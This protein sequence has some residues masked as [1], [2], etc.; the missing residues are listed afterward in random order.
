MDVLN[1]DS[2]EHCQTLPVDHHNM[3][4]SGRVVTTGGSYN[5]KAFNA[6]CTGTVSSVTDIDE[7]QAAALQADHDFYSFNTDDA[8]CITASS[9]D[10]REHCSNSTIYQ[11]WLGAYNS[12][13]A[14][15]DSIESDPLSQAATASGCLSGISDGTGDVTKASC[16][17][18]EG[19]KSFA[20]ANVVTKTGFCRTYRLSPDNICISLDG[21]QLLPPTNPESASQ[22]CTKTFRSQ[23]TIRV[24]LMPTGAMA[25]AF[26]N[27]NGHMGTA[28]A[29]C[30]VRKETI[31]KGGSCD[32]EKTVTC[33]RVCKL[34]DFDTAWGP[35]RVL[36][37]TQCDPTICEGEYAKAACADA[38][39][40]E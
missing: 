25:T 33:F 34:A 22:L 37:E 17:S 16:T 39:M 11:H 6:K 29:E 5:P 19:S 32:V 40:M 21:G 1:S 23:V 38:A 2:M 20:L 14:K 35:P 15:V 8:E 24:G 13:H 31:C 26:E 28:V 12:T 27:V 18:C 30:N 9:C 4:E 7:C 36:D 3:G 10:I